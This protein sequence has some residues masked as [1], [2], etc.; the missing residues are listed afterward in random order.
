MAARTELTRADILP[1]EQYAR[2]RAA[3]RKAMVEIKRSRRLAVGPFATLCFENY[4]TMWQQVHE[5]LHIEKGGE[6][7][8]ADELHAY[9]PLIPKGRELVATLMLEIDDPVRRHALLSR[10][11]GIE[12]HVGIELN[13]ETIAARPEAEVERTTAEGKT[14]SVHFLHFDFTDA[15]AAA[16]RTPG[17]RIVV[18]ITHPDYGHLAVMPEPVR[19]ALAG[20]FA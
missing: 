5:M 7:Q 19:A 13:G 16:F 1:M 17:A 4:D 12:R 8:I 11:G 18:G 10:L 14:S 9:N 6:E 15:Q 2:E 20:D 3:R